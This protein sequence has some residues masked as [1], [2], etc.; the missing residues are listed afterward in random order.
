MLTVLAVLAV[1]AALRAV[2]V[3]VAMDPAEWILWGWIPRGWILRRHVMRRDLSW[4]LSATSIAGSRPGVV[5]VHCME[6]G[7]SSTLPNVAPLPYPISP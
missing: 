4:A 7:R 6:S 3:A 5:S 2:P 1:L